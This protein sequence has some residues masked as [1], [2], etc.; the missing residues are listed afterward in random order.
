MRRSHHH[1]TRLELSQIHVSVQEVSFLCTRGVI[2]LHRND[3]KPLKPTTFAK[4]ASQRLSRLI[5]QPALLPIQIPNP[6][7][8]L[9]VVGEPALQVGKGDDGFDACLRA[10]AWARRAGVFVGEDFDA[11][12]DLIAD[13]EADEAAF[14]VGDAGRLEIEAAAAEGARQRVAVRNR[15]EINLVPG[16][17]VF[18]RADTRIEGALLFRAGNFLQRQDEPLFLRLLVIAALDFLDDTEQ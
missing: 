9:Q 14:A 16:A 15:M 3:R 4:L 6:L 17:A 2:H 8:L 10:G 5:K 1:T 7:R 11:V 12:F 13:F 18:K